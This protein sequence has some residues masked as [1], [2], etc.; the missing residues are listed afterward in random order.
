MRSIQAVS[1]VVVMGCTL[2]SCLPL[3]AIIEA[4][5]VVK[6]SAA[7]AEAS[8]NIDF[9]A[10]KGNSPAWIEYPRGIEARD[11]VSKTPAWIEYPRN[12]EARDE[13]SKT[14]AWIE[15]P[16]DIEARDEMPKTPT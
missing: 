12:I 11:E 9:D 3:N 14:P 7:S 2:G 4:K 1:I 15:Y 6:K 16:R 8:A 5:E 10:D 13:V